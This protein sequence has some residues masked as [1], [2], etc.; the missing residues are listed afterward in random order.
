MGDRDAIDLAFNKKRANDR[1]DWLA[2]M[3]PDTYLVN[4]GGISYKTF[5][6]REFI[7]FS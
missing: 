3:D 5:I 1:K 7:L 2:R 6:D 4:E